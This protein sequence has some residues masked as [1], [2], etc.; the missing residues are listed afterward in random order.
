MLLESKTFS[1]LQTLHEDYWQHHMHAYQHRNGLP[2]MAVERAAGTCDRT[3]TARVCGRRVAIYE[4]PQP[5]P[6]NNKTKDISFCWC[7]L[8]SSTTQTNKCAHLDGLCCCP[9]RKLP[10]VPE[11]P[12]CLRHEKTAKT[13]DTKCLF[14]YYL[15][16]IQFLGINCLFYFIILWFLLRSSLAYTGSDTQRAPAPQWAAA[17][18]GARPADPTHLENID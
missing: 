6:S 7:L 5:P 8:R 15:I 14:P 13:S 11:F 1:Q 16:F 10:R 18:A 3:R 12:A 2:K 4:T 9:D 17:W